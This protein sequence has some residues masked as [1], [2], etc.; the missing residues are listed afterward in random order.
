MQKEQNIK[1]NAYGW[2]EATIKFPEFD[3]FEIGIHDLNLVN[4]VEIV[5]N[6]TATFVGIDR[7][8]IT[9]F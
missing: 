2:R 4:N 8:I 1:L 9:E 3:G 7:A 5:L 6:V